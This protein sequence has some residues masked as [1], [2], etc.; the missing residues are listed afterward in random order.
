M[1][2]L[3]SNECINFVIYLRTISNSPQS[4]QD[5]LNNVYKKKND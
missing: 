2:T 1:G 4:I 3:F 5:I